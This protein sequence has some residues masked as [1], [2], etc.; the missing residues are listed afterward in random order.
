MCLHGEDQRHCET[1][2]LCSYTHLC[3]DQEAVAAGVSAAFEKGDLVVS[4]LRGHGHSVA[5]WLAEEAIPSELIDKDAGMYRGL[6]GGDRWWQ[7]PIF[8]RCRIGA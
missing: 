8:C 6:F 3:V 5:R 7:S 2:T 1:P 4:N